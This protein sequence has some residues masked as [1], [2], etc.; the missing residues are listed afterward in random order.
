[1]SLADL[2]S[3]VLTQIAGFLDQPTDVAHL[4]QTCR[5]MRDV[6]VQ[7]EN[8]WRRL[9]HKHKNLTFKLPSLTWREQCLSDTSGV[10]RHLNELDGATGDLLS[11]TMAGAAMHNEGQ[12][13][14]GESCSVVLPDLWVCL[15]PDCG[16]VGC[17]RY[18]REHG[19]RHF[20]RS[21][22]PLAIKPR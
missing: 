8:L 16:N 22:H 14:K 1:M 17:G 20:A 2:P 3:E 9:L 12:A 11:K 6:C 10:C 4:M 13:C 7:E 15:H 5:T 21:E 18:K 19:L